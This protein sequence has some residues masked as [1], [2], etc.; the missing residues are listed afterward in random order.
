[1]RKEGQEFVRSVGQRSKRPLCSTAK[2]LE[3]GAFEIVNAMKSLPATSTTSSATV[4]LLL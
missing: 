3:C 1:M 2:I 4:L